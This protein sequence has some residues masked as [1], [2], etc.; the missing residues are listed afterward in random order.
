MFV[1][2]FFFGNYK[3]FQQKIS[4]KEGQH[5]LTHFFL[6]ST[7]KTSFWHGELVQGKV[8]DP[9]SQVT[10]LVYA[11][12]DLFLSSARVLCSDEAKQ[13]PQPVLCLHSALRWIGHHVHEV[14]QL[15][16]GGYRQRG[17]G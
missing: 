12:R 2:F 16:E 1:F 4:T 17:H 9:A 5:N 6:F 7:K 10:L 14:R 13:L 11:R 8:L 15:V 3:E